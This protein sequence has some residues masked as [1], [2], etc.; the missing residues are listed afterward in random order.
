MTAS[1]TMPVW[2][3]M[4]RL[5]AIVVAADKR[6]AAL[7]DVPTLAEVGLPQVNREAF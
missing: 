2:T 1:I 4:G 5:I 3:A 7:P 6:V